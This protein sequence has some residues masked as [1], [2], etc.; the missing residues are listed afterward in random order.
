MSFKYKMLLCLLIFTVL[1][2]FLPF[3]IAGVYHIGERYPIIILPY[4]EGEVL[5]YAI[6]VSGLAI[7]IV[8]LFI[9]LQQNEIKVS[10]KRTLIFIDGDD[11]YK[12]AICITN[13]NG[14]SITINSIGMISSDK[15]EGKPLLCYFN[16][17]KYKLPIEIKEYSSEYIL[18]SSTDFNLALKNW[19]KEL[20]EKGYKTRSVIFQIK[21][22]NGKILKMHSKSDDIIFNSKSDKKALSEDC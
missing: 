5:S 1:V 16:P 12:E 3:A 21:L 20:E 4:S 8:A 2:L 15:I 11:S 9:A 6:T 10:L 14:F 17:V 22:A 7:S 13:N 18:F 19:K